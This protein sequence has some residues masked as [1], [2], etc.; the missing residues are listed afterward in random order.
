MSKT[1]TKV[2]AGNF[3]EEKDWEPDSK[4]PM[5]RGKVEIDGREFATAFWP[6]QSKSGMNY[7]SVQI[8]PTDSR[9]Q[10]GDGALFQRNPK[11]HKAP[12]MSGPLEIHGV[13]FEGSVWKQKAE[14]GLEYY[15]M[16]VELVQDAN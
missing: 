9:E 12:I 8:T 4:K 3:F 6:R 11:S 14:S 2:G 5:L 10:V 13:K 15:R 7:L 16:K 1:Y